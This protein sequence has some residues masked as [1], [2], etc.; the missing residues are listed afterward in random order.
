[1][2]TVED[3]HPDSRR[4][5]GVWNAL[6]PP[7]RPSVDDIA[8]YAQASQNLR[9]LGVLIQGFTPELVDLA[10]RNN[11]SRVIAIDRD[12][13]LFPAMRLLG[14]QDWILVE[15]RY[16]DWRIFLPE[17]EGKLDV[18]FGDGSL[19]LLAF[20][21]EWKQALHHIYRYLVPGGRMVLRLSF[22][23]EENFDLDLYVKETLRRLDAKCPALNPE[24]RFEMLRE[25]VSEFRIAFG[26]ASAGNTGSVNL[27]R[28]AELVHFFHTEFASRYGHWKEWERARVAM[29]AVEAIRDGSEAG[30]AV[31]HW[32]TA[33]AVIESCGFRMKDAQWSGSRPAPGV[34]R[35]LALERV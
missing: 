7:L 21:E 9:G 32:E 18:V 30:K 19:T 16:D 29:P 26:L 35:F 28:R 25:V 34:M 15:E 6:A 12:K 4:L 11:A 20:P 8:W 24:Q 23:P 10:L 31:P 17:L 5:L 2:E 22:Q 27:Q 13:P 3:L 1:M 14:H 33:I